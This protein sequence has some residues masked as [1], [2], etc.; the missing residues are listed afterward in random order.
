MENIDL[1]NITPKERMILEEVIRKIRNTN[2]ETSQNSIDPEKENAFLNKLRAE[3]VSKKIP[4]INQDE[5][6]LLQFCH[7][8]NMREFIREEFTKNPIDYSKLAND[9]SWMG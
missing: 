2:N 4:T 1:N 6:E 7:E 9:S 8:R 3:R 5:M